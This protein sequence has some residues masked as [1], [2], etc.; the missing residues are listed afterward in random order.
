MIGGAGHQPRAAPSGLAGVG[1]RQMPIQGVHP[2][3]IAN[4]PKTPENT[5]KASANQR[6]GSTPKLLPTKLVR[7]DSPPALGYQKTVTVL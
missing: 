5:K 4:H 6:I 7:L 1:D 2:H 3:C